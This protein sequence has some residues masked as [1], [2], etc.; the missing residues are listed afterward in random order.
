MYG[1]SPMAK[2]L[3]GKQATNLNAGLQAAIE[4]SPANM[5]DKSMAKMYGSKKSMAKK[6]KSDAQR[7]ARHASEADKKSPT[8]QTSDL[9]ERVKTMDT[10]KPTSKQSTKDINKR[11]N[12]VVSNSK[13][14]KGANVNFGTAFGDAK[15]AGKKTFDYKGKS[16]TTETK[17][18]KANRTADKGPTVKNAKNNVDLSKTT[19]KKDATIKAPNNKKSLTTNTKSKLAV[20]GKSKKTFKDTKV[21]KALSNVRAKAAESR[22][23][24]K[25]TFDAAKA[26]RIAKRKAKKNKK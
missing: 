24:R 23:K 17:Q 20:D 9:L 21:G 19:K 14:G 10:P 4:N 1:K 7:M 3:I 6:Y 26:E 22:A 18:E 16:Y 2:A 25:A 15:K 8:R 5:M 13:T 11:I 12:E